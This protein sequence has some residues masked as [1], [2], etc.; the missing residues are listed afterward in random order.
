MAHI[1]HT[2]GGTPYISNDWLIE[3]VESVCEDMQVTL[4]ED[5]KVEVLHVVANSFDANYGIAWDNF[6]SAIQTLIDDKEKED[7]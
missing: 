4:T 3:D 7:A 5:E 6:Q 2:E 1:K